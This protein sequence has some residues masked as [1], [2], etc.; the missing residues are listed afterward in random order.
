MQ[1]A[2]IGPHL[3]PLIGIFAHFGNFKVNNLK[4]PCLRVVHDI[5]GFDVSV[6]HSMAVHV[7]K[8]TH[9]LI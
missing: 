3:K 8:P 9:K 4:L 7:S 6:A 1:G 2:G 5:L